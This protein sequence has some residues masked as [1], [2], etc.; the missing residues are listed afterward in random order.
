MK[1]KKLTLRL[2]PRVAGAFETWRRYDAKRQK[3][4]R[5]ELSRI[6]ATEGLSRDMAEIVSRMLDA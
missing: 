1:K 5:G 6:A 2:R 3:L 4:I